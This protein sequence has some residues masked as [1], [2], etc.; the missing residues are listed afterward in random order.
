MN[1]NPTY[2]ELAQR[3]K[4]LENE[5]VRLRQAE[6]SII[7]TEKMYRTIFEST[8]TA[9]MISNE[10][11]TIL[12]VNSEF[13]ELTG[14]SKAEIEGKKSWTEFV[15]KDDLGL[16]MEYHRSRRIDSSSAPRN[17]EFR[18]VNRNGNCKNI[19]ATAA[20]ISGTKNGLASFIDITE[21]KKAE[22][23]KKEREKLEGVLEMAGAVC[24]EMNQPMQTILGNS[25]LLLMDMQKDNPYY[26]RINSI[27][28]Q[29]ERI[30]ALMGKLMNIKD[31]KTMNYI[32]GKIIDIDKASK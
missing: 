17:H 15:A 11:M 24:H 3:V 20:I 28:D 16:L 18:L 1:Q 6:E 9:M 14:Y 12:M 19:Y 13:E 5:A 4:E 8:G 23:E 29:V 2:E 31:Y 22:E 7:Y 27:K 10:A 21:L 26:E 30:D 25:E 32:Q